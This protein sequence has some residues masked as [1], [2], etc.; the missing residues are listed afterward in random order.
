LTPTCAE[1]HYLGSSYSVSFM[2]ILNLDLR[3]VCRHLL[4]PLD[5]YNDSAQFALQR[6]KKQFLYNEIEAEVS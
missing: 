1:L 6:F 3:L 4:Y 2:L 5:L